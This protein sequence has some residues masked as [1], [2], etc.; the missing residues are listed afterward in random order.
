[1]EGEKVALDFA[2]RVANWTLPKPRDFQLL[3]SVEISMAKTV[4]G[5]SLDSRNSKRSLATAVWGMFVIR[6]VSLSISIAPITSLF[7]LS[8][9]RGCD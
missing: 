1:M 5:P 2:S 4:S 3:R 7:H 9:L 6:N 8:G